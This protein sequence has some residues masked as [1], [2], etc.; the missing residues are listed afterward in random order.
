[1]EGAGVDASEHLLAFVTQTAGFIVTADEGEA[2]HERLVGNAWRGTFG[3]HAI[4]E[5]VRGE[6]DRA[7]PTS[8]PFWNAS[9]AA[10]PRTAARLAGGEE[11]ARGTTCRTMAAM[12]PAASNSVVRGESSGD[13]H[14]ELTAFGI[15]RVERPADR[16]ADV[17]E[18][19]SQAGSPRELL[20][21]DQRGPGSFRERRVVFGVPAQDGLSETVLLETLAREL[22]QCLE[23]AVS[24][25]SMDGVVAD[26]HGLGDEAR[27]GV[28]QLPPGDGRAGHFRDRVEI[29]R[30][31]EYAEQA[32][33]GAFVVGEQR[34]RP[35]DRGPERLVAFRGAARTARSAGGTVRRDALRSRARSS[36]R[37]EPRASSIAR[38]MPSRWRQISATSVPFDASSSKSGRTALARSTKSWTASLAAMPG[39]GCT[40]RRQ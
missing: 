11:E 24:G 32:E 15:G 2:G 7:R 18:V 4:A 23:Q 27:H 37:P 1:M 8:P 12:S 35:V 19:R 34:V 17:V 21:P 6:L 20:R 28:E 30:P 5:R 29:E 10:A 26:H 36:P 16:G 39:E 9:N 40:N 13:A 31:D 14:G 25:R 22:P 38:G 33:L 3:V